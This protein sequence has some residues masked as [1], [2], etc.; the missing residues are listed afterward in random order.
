MNQLF[1]SANI[2]QFI[3]YFGVGGVSALVEWAVFSLLEYTLRIPYLLATV[4]AFLVSTTTNLI[5]GRLFTFKD[6]AYTKNKKKE[7]V[8]VFF[9]SAVGLLFNMLLMYLFVEVAGFDSNLQ[10]TIAKILSTGIVFIWN[11]LSRK[12]WIYKESNGGS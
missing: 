7:A 12:L 2:K 8:L 10:K 6:S 4:L 3:S 9:V 1:S 5:L 11:F